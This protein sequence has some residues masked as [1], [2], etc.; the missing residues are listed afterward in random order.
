MLLIPDILLITWEGHF[1]FS[2]VYRGIYAIKEQLN[3]A[4]SKYLW[5][6]RK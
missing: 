4:E 3:W 6:M 5:H 1:I 2:D